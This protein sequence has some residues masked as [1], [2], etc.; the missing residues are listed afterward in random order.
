MYEFHKNIRAG[1]R[2]FELFE[3]IP[4]RAPAI[5]DPQKTCRAGPRGARAP[6]RRALLTLRY[7]RPT[8]AGFAILVQ[9][10]REND[11][12]RPRAA[13]GQPRN[14]LPTITYLQ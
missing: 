13:R 5:S 3:N 6:A 8:V 7:T 9:K 2:L 14:F 1:A 4:A 12:M 10:L 11:Q